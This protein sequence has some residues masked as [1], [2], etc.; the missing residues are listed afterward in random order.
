[1]KNSPLLK[2]FLHFQ[3]NTEGQK[4]YCAFEPKSSENR[5]ALLHFPYYSIFHRPL[6]RILTES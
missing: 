3:N 4:L 2:S 1:M 5:A 6:T